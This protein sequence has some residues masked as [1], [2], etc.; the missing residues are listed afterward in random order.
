MTKTFTLKHNPSP[1]CNSWNAMGI[2][3]CHDKFIQYFPLAKD[4]VKVTIS[5]KRQHRKGEQKMQLRHESFCQ[6]AGI[7]IKDDEVQITNQSAHALENMFNLK[8]NISM[9]SA[10][11]TDIYVR[12]QY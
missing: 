7:I 2:S 9:D 8:S 1:N 11:Y 3:L 5:T 10:K 4:N 12:F 6:V